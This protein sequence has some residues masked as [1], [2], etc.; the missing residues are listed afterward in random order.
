MAV[1]LVAGFVLVSRLEQRGITLDAGIMSYMLYGPILVLLPGSAV[2]AATGRPFRSGL[3]AGAW[4][5]LLG[6]PP[7]AP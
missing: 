3:W 1:A 4:A 6:A 7:A 2:A 5:T